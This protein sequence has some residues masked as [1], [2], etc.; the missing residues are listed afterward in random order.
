MRLIPLFVLVAFSFLSACAG[1]KDDTDS[2][3]DTDTSGDTD[4]GDSDT[5]AP[6]DEDGD[7]YAVSGGD[8]NDTNYYVNP[9]ASEACDEV[10]N[11]C[12]G[13]VDEGVTQTFYR[14]DDRDGYGT[15]TSTEACTPPTGY[16]V[17][18]GDCDD[19]DTA[20][21]PRAPETDCTDPND[22]NCD[23]SVGAV[24]ND[25]DGYFAC[26]ECDDRAA[27]VNPV[28]AE[29]CNG[30]DDNCDDVIDTDAIN[31]GTYY[32]DADGDTYGDSSTG[33][34]AC[35]APEGTVA[36]GGDCDDSLSTY[37]P[38]ADESDC[39]DSNDYNCDGS[40]GYDDADGDGF[41]A[42]QECDDT[43]SAINS[44][45]IEVCDGVDN[46][47]DGT[48][49]EGGGSSTSAWYLD[50]DGDGYG[51]DAHTSTECIAP[52]G[53]VAAN[54]DCDDLDDAFHPGA[55]EDCTDPTDYNCDGSTGYADAD[56]DGSA[57][58]EDCDDTN[59]EAYPG[60]VEVCDGAD[61]DC[62]TTVDV[63]AVNAT[64]FYADVDDDSYGDAT[65]RLE[66]CDASVAGFVTND[67]DCDDSSAAYNPSA[68]ETCDDPTDYNCDGSVGYADAD[69]DGFPACEECNDGDGAINGSATEACD[70]VDNDCDGDTDEA[71][72]T[73][74]G[75]WYADADADGYGD[76]TAS[77]M[78]CSA[79]EGY[80]AD[81]T[82]CDDAR[83]AF[84]PGADES[85]CTDPNDYNCDGSVGYADADGDGTA[86]CEDCDDLNA[87]AY[88]GG[89]EVCDGADNNCDTN[90]D[91]ASA[92]DASVWYADSDSDTFGDS[93]VMINACTQPDGFVAD[94]TDCDDARGGDYPGAPEYCD[95]HDNDCNTLVDDDAVDATMWYADADV[96]DYGD[97]SV[98]TQACVQP[99]GY[100]ADANDCDDTDANA[101]PSAMEICDG[102]DNDCDSAVDEGAI[103]TSAFFAD[104]DSD[105]FGD[106]V[107][108]VEACSA[109]FGYVNDSNDCDDTD[110]NAYPGATESCDD[111]DNDCD[112][113][114]DEAGAS[115]ES[116][117]YL[118]ADAD[119]YGDPAMSVYSCEPDGYVANADDCDDSEALAWTGNTD[120]CDGVDND[121]DGAIDEDCSG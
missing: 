17:Q 87:E 4:T 22:Y 120:D 46:N 57:A 6:I 119:S 68:A 58:C 76:A 44:S 109:P 29:L 96:D 28:A 20:Y 39:A 88:P 85:D 113:S 89:V 100:V 13:S 38:G 41:A 25:R 5:A 1:G 116:T 7:G 31:R 86:A 78:S 121:C 95:N 99:D 118:D 11:N 106:A 8:C 14:D 56:S 2:Q 33:V 52:D 16:T 37:H 105:G 115:G 24:D 64:V 111:V 34:E 55:T 101:F 112:G 27:A 43:N 23:G 61:N 94:D 114:I 75:I 60:G 62:D 18:T 98:S 59:A 50:L 91:E 15:T 103:D 97:A 12:N 19:S 83:G 102:V 32:T 74:E 66:S 107:S 42:C 110:A 63:A 48:I 21:H 26:E 65:A 71:G 69:G 3:V 49:D 54:G 35:D 90:T 51:D 73:G 47:C 80:V 30:V 40:V 10:D 67:L 53:Y 45:A 117:W 70:G 108:T 81:S 104:A 77:V 36:A 72:A 92:L 93:A 84:H 82:D 9:A 79:P